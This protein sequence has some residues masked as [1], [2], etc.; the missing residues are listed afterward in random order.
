MD[1]SNKQTLGSKKRKFHA[2]PKTQKA[3]N[4]KLE[5]EIKQLRKIEKI[6]KP[7]VKSNYTEND[8]SPDNTWHA[9]A[10]D[11][12]ALGGTASERLGPII[13]M[14]SVNVR[15]VV[16]TSNSDTYDTLR[17]MFVQYMDGNT[18][19]NY[20]VNHD[21]NVWE[22]TSTSY[23]YLVPFNTQTA[24]RYRVLYDEMFHV[25]ENGVAEISRNL[26]FSA[27]ASPQTKPWAI[28]KIVFTGDTG[29]GL[30]PIESGLILGWVCSDSTASPNPKITYTVK[31]NYTDS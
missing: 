25:N 23:P 2:K 30:P 11:Y 12:P 22:S 7:P 31:V 1:T 4:E 28:S 21:S 5:K 15:F 9:M 10:L 13:E 26:L 19:G 29:L 3:I 18:D 14:K 6:N 16:T 17:V 24:S 8:I 27:K 20:P